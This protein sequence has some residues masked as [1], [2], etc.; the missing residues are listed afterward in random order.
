[1][2]SAGDDLH[3]H[4]TDVETQQRKATLVGHGDCITSI[5]PHPTRPDV[6]LTGSLDG[7]VKTWDTTQGTKETNTI[8][9]GSPVWGCAYSPTGE[10]YAAVSETG[11]I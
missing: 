10:Y 9:M 4:V 7:K 5:S 6:F 11:T 2:I 1:M 8:E 3:I